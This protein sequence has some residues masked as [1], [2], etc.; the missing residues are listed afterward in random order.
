MAAAKKISVKAL[1]N[2]THDGKSFK[3]DE[4]LKINE[5]EAKE[6]EERGC[7]EILEK[8]PKETNTPGKGQE[9]PENKGTEDPKDEDKKGGE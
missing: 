9:D 3:I 5:D 2:I 6:L 4:N 7:V 1:V 8:Q